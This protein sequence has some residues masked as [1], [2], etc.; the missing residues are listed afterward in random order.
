MSTAPEAI[1]ANEAGIPYAAIAMSTDFDCWKEDEKPVSREG[2]L[3]I[4]KQN[5]D[6]VISLILASLPKIA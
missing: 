6:K 2:V 3:E 5:V 1:L 4:F